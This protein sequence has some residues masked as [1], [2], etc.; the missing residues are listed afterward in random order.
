MV[1]GLNVLGHGEAALPLIHLQGCDNCAFWFSKSIHCCNFWQEQLTFQTYYLHSYN[2]YSYIFI[3]WIISYYFNSNIK[4][5]YWLTICYTVFPFSSLRTGQTH[6]PA[7]VQSNQV[8]S[9]HDYMSGPQENLRVLQS[10]E[11]EYARRVAFATEGFRDPKVLAGAVGRWVPLEMCLS[12]L[13]TTQNVH[14]EHVIW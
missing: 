6:P 11:A 14:V 7:L 2:I 9:E 12:N 3:F 13:S 4:Y 1:D 5:K 8:W 10:Y